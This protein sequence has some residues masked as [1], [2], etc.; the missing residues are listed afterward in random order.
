L[1]VVKSKQ[2][3]YRTER[4]S[5]GLC[6]GC[7]KRPP[8][9]DRNYCSSCRTIKTRNVDLG[10][11][12]ADRRALWTKRKLA[13]YAAYGGAACACC[14]ETEECFLSLDHVNDNGGQH[15]K[16]IGAAN[17][18]VWLERHHYPPGFRVLCMNCNMGRQ[19]NG[20][21]CPHEAKRLRLVKK[22]GG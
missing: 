15:R 9:E 22:E 11:K 16:E 4:R 17:L 21:V 6:P 5:A 12:D 19:R 13:A 7:G 18:Y 20:G 8:D 14:G 2:A 3:Q 10:R 1:D